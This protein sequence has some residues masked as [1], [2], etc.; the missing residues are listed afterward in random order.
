MFFFYFFF[1]FF[2]KKLLKTIK[3]INVSQLEGCK[4][5]GGVCVTLAV[6][7]APS[8]G[9]ASSDGQAVS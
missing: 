3:R 4:F 7:G 5:M 6:M 9:I 2:L 8:L 1:L